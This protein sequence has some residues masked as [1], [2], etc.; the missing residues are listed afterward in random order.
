MVVIFAGYFVLAAL[1][2]DAQR[3]V[4]ASLLMVSASAPIPV[5]A[6]SQAKNDR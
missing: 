3:I 6:M 1:S 5:I 4:V 2:G